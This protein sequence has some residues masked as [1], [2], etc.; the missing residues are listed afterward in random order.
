MFGSHSS[1]NTTASES[2]GPAILLV[3]DEQAILDGLRRQLRRKYT[4]STAL[5]GAEGLELL[6]QQEFAVVVSDMRM[7]GM[8]G[9][10]FLAKVRTGYPD[11]VR[12]LLTGQADT[13]SAISAINDGQIYRFLTKSCPPD[14]LQSALDSAAELNRLMTAEKD[15]LEKTLRATVQTL[16]STLS[17]AQPQAFARAVRITRTVTAIANVLEVE[18]PWEVEITAMLSHLGAVSLPHEVLNKL[19]RGLPL[20]QD[21]KVMVDRVPAAGAELVGAIPRLE[22][23]G[24]AIGLQRARYDGEDAHWAVPV[25]D[26]LPIGARILR[27]AV[28][29]DNARIRKQPEEAYEELTADRGADDPKVLDALAR[30]HSVDPPDVPPI[31]V[32]LDELRTGMIL[33]GDVRT[34]RGVMLVGRGSTVTPT[35]KQR[36][37]NFPT[38]PR[39]R[40]PRAVRGAAAHGR[41]QAATGVVGGGVAGQGY[42]AWRRSTQGGRDGPDWLT[43]LAR[44]TRRRGSGATGRPGSWSASAVSPPSDSVTS[45]SPARL[46]RPTTPA[47]C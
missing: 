3:D 21:E 24:R 36:L 8:D 32:S 43:W 38:A 22:H 33:A 45:W 14:L 10:T 44:R 47:A 26:D 42:G 6:A 1:R 25:G 20:T 46:G 28:D 2:G 37:L 4:V 30:W 27:V 31:L 17:L 40:R 39:H 23:V 12:L 15:L 13:Q 41:R 19:D 9:A 16:A 7:P 18:R 11:T 29:F 5:G 34:S 35:L